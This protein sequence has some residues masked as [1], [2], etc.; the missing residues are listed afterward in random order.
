[1]PSPDL[2]RCVVLAGC[3]VVAACSPRATQVSNSGKGAFEAALT[4]FGDGFAMAWYD[5]RDGNGE[6]YVR[7]LDANGRPVG[8]E[9]RLTRSAEESYDASIEQLGDAMVLAWY[10]E[11]GTGQQIARLGMFTRDGGRRW[12]YAFDSGTRNPV[13]R[14]GPAEIFCAWIQAEDEGREAV[15]AAWWDADGRRRGAPIR[16]G[17]ASKTT[18]NLNATLDE[19]GAAWVVYDAEVDTRASE[20]YLARTGESAVTLMR[21][22]KDDGA[23]SKYPDVSIGAGGRAALSWQDERDGNVEV[24]LLSARVGDFV[25]EIEGRAMRVT[26]TPGESNGAYLNWNGDRLGL[27]W[28]DKTLGQHEVYFQ[29]FDRSGASR[30]GARRITD[31][32]PWSLVPAIRPAGRGFA[33]GWSEY[34]PA[35]AEVHSGTAEVFFQLIP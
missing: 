21:L 22:T 28:A 14:T 11:T 24:Y 20:V 18:W 29:S 8:P 26:N 30:E 17:P 9:Q 25:G 2:R 4:R 7:L 32:R 13:V 34:V 33:L 23:S 3:V 27:A 19:T 16:L 35:S 12:E 1:M 5:T 10:D 15:F 6:I 31:T